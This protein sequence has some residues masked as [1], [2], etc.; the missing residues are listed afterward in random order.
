MRDKGRV[1]PEDMEEET[2]YNIYKA[3]P[4]EKIAM[5]ETMKLFRDELLEMI[6]TYLDP[7]IK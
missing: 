7:W 6:K 1:R 3:K 5:R 2:N 4:D